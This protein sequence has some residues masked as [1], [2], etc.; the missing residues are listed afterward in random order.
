MMLPGSEISDG[1]FKNHVCRLGHCD[2][3]SQ[4]KTDYII[5]AVML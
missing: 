3:M 2:A 4:K 5:R 1:M